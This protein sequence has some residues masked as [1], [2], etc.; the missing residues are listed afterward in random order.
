MVAARTLDEELLQEEPLRVI[1][2]D[3]TDTEVAERLTGMSTYDRDEM[4]TH[5]LPLVRY[6]AGSMARHANASSIVDYDDLVG[7]GTE[8]LISAVD[9]FNPSYNVRFSTWAVMHIR[10]TIQDALRRL[11]PLSRSLRTKSKEIE[12]AQYTLA[13]RHG[14]WPADVEVAQELGISL[15]RLRNLQRDINRSVV[16]LEAVN[17]NAD[18]D[19]GMN[20]LSCLAETNPDTDPESYLDVIEMR[21]ILRQAVE[22]L[23][24]R[25]R[26]ITSLYYNNSLSMREISEQLGISESRVSQLH[27]RILRTLSREMQRLLEINA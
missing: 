17:S 19:S 5:H 16:S 4:I 6:V 27:A 9:T 3:E 23:P 1:G 26:L 18:E 21:L 2:R 24:E 20:L 15:D 10:T 25:E 14:C 7:Y 22:S 11:D 8:G 13:N 12:H